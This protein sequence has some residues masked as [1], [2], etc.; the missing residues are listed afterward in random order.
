M[1][2]KKLLAL[3]VSA[4]C[5]FSACTSSD[6]SASTGTPEQ[7][8]SQSTSSSTS[9]S[10]TQTEPTGQ[11][12]SVV[13]KYKATSSTSEGESYEK[14]VR[15]RWDDNYYYYTLYLGYVE[16]VPLNENVPFH[17]YQGNAYS[18]TF[19]ESSTTAST[20]TQQSVAVKERC[21]TNK[22]SD[23]FGG[24]VEGKIEIGK[25]HWPVKGSIGGSFEWGN[26][27]EDATSVS[28]MSSTSYTQAEEVSK[29]YTDE[30]SFAFDSSC[31]IGYYRYIMVG[32]FDVYATVLAELDELDNIVKYYVDYQ[33]VLYSYGFTLDYSKNSRFDDNEYEQLVLDMDEV[34]KL[35]IPT[36]YIEE[37]AGG[38]ED[39]GIKGILYFD[40][41]QGTGGTD[42]AYISN[43]GQPNQ[44]LQ[45]PTRSGYIF[46][47]YYSAAD[48]GAGERYFDQNMNLLKAVT[49][50]NNK[51]YAHWVS[52]NKASTLIP[53]GSNYT[54]SKRN[55]KDIAW[56]NG[57]ATGAFTTPY[58]NAEMT[59][60]RSVGCVYFNLKIN[61]GIRVEEECYEHFSL[62]QVYNGA[63]VK[64][65]QLYRTNV[66]GYGIM[67]TW[68]EAE[69]YYGVYIDYFL[70]AGNGLQLICG[71]SGSAK[72]EWSRGSVVVS[73]TPSATCV[74]ASNTYA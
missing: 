60:L 29:T 74:G 32:T 46:T 24:G 10:G 51:L 25:E 40:K 18:K 15:A 13:K 4:L 20:I 58:S 55:P 16:N 19:K 17:E 3:F 7:S 27:S 41:N 8:A 44:T 59:E 21:V 23:S 49:E 62:R 63:F 45:A 68:V 14:V 37:T 47:G 65:L 39:D 52:S 69:L 66:D 9:Q 11:K 43:A 61:V 53:S 30:T 72:N 28:D 64:D 71:I 35:P 42:Y 34:T 70:I 5:L 50:D 73:Y 26:T 56:D 67:H 12:V 22:T 38:V 54:L 1:K 48:V 2:M 6:N 31:K 36:E 33:T 57:S